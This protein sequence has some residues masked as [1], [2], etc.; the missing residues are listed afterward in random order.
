M[1]RHTIAFVA[2]V[3]PLLTMSAERVAGEGTVP[4]NA[5]AQGQR[6]YLSQ[7]YIDTVIQRAYTDFNTAMSVAGTGLNQE[8]A[9]G[10]AK[11][12]VSRLKNLARNDVNKNYILWK[13][14]EL[15]YQIFLE[16]REIARKVHERKVIQLNQLVTKFNA[17]TGR[18]RPDFVKL[19]EMQHQFAETDPGKGREIRY[20]V[21]QRTV[22]VSKKVLNSL[23]SALQSGDIERAR[24]EIDYCLHNAAYLH[25]S[26]KQVQQYQ[27]KLRAQLDLGDLKKFIEEDMYVMTRLMNKNDLHGAWRKLASVDR[28]L[29]DFA[30]CSSGPELK[31]YRA[32]RV[33]LENRL[34]VKEDSL[35]DAAIS[36]YNSQ[37]RAAAIEFVDAVLRVHGVSGEK[38][39]VVDQA[40]I[41]AALSEMNTANPE[42]R[43]VFVDLADDT[44]DPAHNPLLDLA[45]KAKAK[46]QVVKDSIRAAEEEAARIAQA[47]YE[48]EHRRE[49]RREKRRRRREERDRAREEER[50][51]RQ[52]EEDEQE[53]A[54]LESLQ[55]QMQKAQDA[56]AEGEP[57]EAAQSGAPQPA[58]GID[59]Q[60][61]QQNIV[62][63]YALIE[64]NDVEG[65]YL[66]FM[67]L[68]EPLKQH[69]IPEAFTVLEQTVMSAY[70]GT[71]VAAE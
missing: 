19:S 18:N 12:V 29:D 22:S 63:I 36:V 35:V 46:A 20:L 59:Q 7:E 44:T 41:G 65:A 64:Q 26:E 69:L 55:S 11:A 66:R 67:S 16:E 62:L 9:I 38:I 51:A 33:R 28:R 45:A 30:K 48:K 52:R 8:R 4:G 25:I 50:I 56:L 57:R 54:R 71:A 68:R 42:L 60:R 58:M 24:K 6:E 10:K 27:Q 21:D 61:A 37:G 2:F 43:K 5:S 14:S 13:V 40:M 34:G 53:I 15:E 39:S 32:K 17:E 3:I 31:A 47:A 70:R 1:L 49:I 23:N